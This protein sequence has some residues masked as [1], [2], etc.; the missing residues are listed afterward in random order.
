MEAASKDLSN[1][2]DELEYSAGNRDRIFRL[3]ASNLNKTS[4]FRFTLY[5]VFE[6]STYIKPVEH[7]IEINFVKNTLTFSESSNIALSRT[8]IEYLLLK[9]FSL[10]GEPVRR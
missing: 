3:V 6:R 7:T 1:F 8:L 10:D 2:F 4:Q 9:E 5:N